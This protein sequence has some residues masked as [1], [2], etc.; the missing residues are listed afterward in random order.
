MLCE[1]LDRNPGPVTSVTQATGTMSPWTA[2]L[3]LDDGGPAALLESARS[4]ARI[5]RYSILAV[6]VDTV[7]QA[8]GTRCTIRVGENERSYTADPASEVRR[9]QAARALESNGYTSPFAGGIIGCVSYE[10]RHAFE[11]LPQMAV[12]DLGL[13]HWWFVISDECLVFDHMRDT[14]TAVV[15]SNE[16]SPIEAR[17]RATDILRSARGQTRRLLGPVSSD[18]KVG[19]SFTRD[20]YMDA[21]N[22]AL[23]YIGAGDVYQVNLAQ[24]L[25]VELHG[26]SR[27]LYAAL[28]SVNPSPFAAY[29]RDDDFAYVGCS[30]ER[31]VQ[32]DGRHAE[33]RPIAGTRP[34]GV[35]SNDDDRLQ[36]ELLLSEKER[37]EHVMLVDLERN[38][39][40]RVC[41]YGSVLVDELMVLEHYS[42]V[43]H[44]V[45]NVVGDL[46]DGCDTLD[47]LAA[48][49]PGGTIT[50]CPKIRCMEI[51]DELEPVARHAYTGAIGYI[52]DTGHM[53]TNMVIRTVMLCNGRAY[54]P[55]GAGIVADSVPAFEYDETLH[56]AQAMIRAIETSTGTT[57]C[58]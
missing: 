47:L 38:D 21:V 44:I 10:A 56:K 13:P 41:S 43:N 17:E 15:R 50:G 3:A 55:V 1:Q 5:G 6:D 16:R 28:R 58:L 14:V 37:A 18:G 33:T 4:D 8:R 2:F 40:G 19:S 46:A 39:L 26:D 22:R 49:F 29:L 7:W 54:I 24:R 25:D 12:D 31:L 9:I 20:G 45:S 34:R 53:D 57:L 52:S 48:M 51:I 27:T 35:D 42:H 32:L 30:P 11:Q 23:A 36:A